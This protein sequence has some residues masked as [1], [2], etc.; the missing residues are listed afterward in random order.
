MAHDKLHHHHHHHPPPLSVLPEEVRGMGNF[1]GRPEH[2]CNS[3]KQIESHLSSLALQQRCI[4]EAKMAL[5]SWQWTK[6]G[7]VRSDSGFLSYQC[8]CDYIF[9]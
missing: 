8:V 3:F 6:V 9:F 5:H 7:F 1:Y 2:P 4:R